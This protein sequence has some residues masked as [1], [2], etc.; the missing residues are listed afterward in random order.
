MASYC[1]YLLIGHTLLAKSIRVGTAKLYLK[2]IVQ[3]FPKH[4][5]DPTLDITTGVQAQRITDV[6]HEAQRWESMPNRQEPLTIELMHH[7]INTSVP[8]NDDGPE[9]VMADWF[10]LGLLA[11]FRCSEWCQPHSNLTMPLN[12]PINLNV[13]G[14]PRA[15]IADDFTLLN[16]RKRTITFTMETTWSDVSYV[17]IRW[18]FQKNGDNGQIITWKKCKEHPNFCPVLA[19]LNILIR[20]GRLNIDPGEPLAVTIT[21]P[22]GHT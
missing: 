20:A 17:N 8:Y 3:L 11:G 2:A 19:V 15:F 13:D 1:T 22:K 21:G 14:S 6:F 9:S 4:D 7:I 18:R 5:W 16:K 12:L 10:V